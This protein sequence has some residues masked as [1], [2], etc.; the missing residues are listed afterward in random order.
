MD[1]RLN[2]IFSIVEYN[3]D[4]TCNVVQREIVNTIKY[5][6]KMYIKQI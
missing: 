6:N 4:G 5:N 3:A 1:F 2:Y